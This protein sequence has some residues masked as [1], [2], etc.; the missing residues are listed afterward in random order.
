MKKQ[1]SLQKPDKI[2]NPSVKKGDLLTDLRV[3]IDQTR[4]SVATAINACLTILYWRIGR[5]F[6]RK[7]SEKE[8]P[9]MG[10]KLLRHCRNN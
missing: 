4:Q 3:M 10:K 1:R 6:V 5:V 7:F 2:A 9:D 8:E